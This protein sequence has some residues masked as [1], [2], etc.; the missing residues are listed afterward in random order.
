MELF[1]KGR[2]MI[3]N[4]LY[5]FEELETYGKIE[6][7]HKH[8]RFLVKNFSEAS[9]YI[10]LELENGNPVHDAIEIPSGVWE[11]IETN[12]NVDGNLVRDEQNYIYAAIW[13]NNNNMARVE[14]RGLD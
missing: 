10:G 3:D 2:N 7:K 9:V 14:V 6:L 11:I 8:S 4:N 1:R 13:E 12:I 5:Y